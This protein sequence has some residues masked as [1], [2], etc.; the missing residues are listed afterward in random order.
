ML[1]STKQYDVTGRRPLLILELVNKVLSSQIGQVSESARKDG[2]WKSRLTECGEV[3][4]FGLAKA[5]AGDGSSPRPN[6]MHH[7]QHGDDDGAVIGAS[8]PT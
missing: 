2:D 8:L 7:Q 5:V 1:A 3:L 4:D 6:R